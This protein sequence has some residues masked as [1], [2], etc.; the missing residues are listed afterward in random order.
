MLELAKCTCC[1]SGM[2]FVIQL[3]LFS[4]AV[5]V[6]RRQQSFS[7]REKHKNE[8]T[9]LVRSAH[10]L[11]CAA[12]NCERVHYLYQTSINSVSF[13]NPTQ[14]VQHTHTLHTHSLSHRS[15]LLTLLCGGC[16]VLDLSG[17]SGG[18]DLLG[19]WSAH[20]VCGVQ[21]HAECGQAVAPQPPAPCQQG[22]QR[23]VSE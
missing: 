3:L 19:S 1:F 4:C 17:G 9:G 7:D 8:L 18:G 2:R 22:T 10:T 5:R 20:L 14:M 13:Y 6:S 16:S 11:H 21:E 12:A 23:P 15:P